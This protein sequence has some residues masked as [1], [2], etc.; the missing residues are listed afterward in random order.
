[1]VTGAALFHRPRHASQVGRPQTNAAPSGAA[2]D[3]E[4]WGGNVVVGISHSWAAHLMDKTAI[5]VDHE[6]NEVFLACSRF[7]VGQFQLVVGSYQIC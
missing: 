3:A 7:I 2:T 1:M 6:P 5:G 4:R